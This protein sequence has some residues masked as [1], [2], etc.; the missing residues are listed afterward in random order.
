MVESS[1]WNKWMLAAALALGACGGVS[2]THVDATPPVD[3]PDVCVPATDQELCAQQADG[4]ACEQ[5]AVVD[6]CGAQRDVD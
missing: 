4:H 3:S 5:H 6:N 1:V 2:E